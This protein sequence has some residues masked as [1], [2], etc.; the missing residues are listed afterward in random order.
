QHHLG[1]ELGCECSSLRHRVSPFRQIL[2]ELS[3]LSSFWG[4][5]HSVAVAPDSSWAVSASWDNTIKVWN[6]ETGR[7]L[8]T[9][10]IP[11]WSVNAVAITP[12]SHRLVFATTDQRIRVWDMETN[13]QVAIIALDGVP[14]CVCVGIISN[15]LAIV[16]GDGDGR[17]YCF[18]V[19]L[20]P[21]S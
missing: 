2:L 10:R 21:K 5:L 4:S 18:G 11:N 14:W 15:G 7:E 3:Y 8:D 1:L 6:V 16:T 20:T 17:V 19:D 13:Q 12:D 9:V